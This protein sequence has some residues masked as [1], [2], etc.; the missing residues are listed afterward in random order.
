MVSFFLAFYDQ[1]SVMFRDSGAKIQTYSNLPI[2]RWKQKYN[3]TVVYSVNSDC[4][5]SRGKQ[6]KSCWNNS[7]IKSSVQLIILRKKSIIF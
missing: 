1:C 4:L 2:F 6:E 7:L 5:F 3:N